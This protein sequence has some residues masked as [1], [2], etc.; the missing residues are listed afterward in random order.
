MN[1]NIRYA[2]GGPTALQKYIMHIESDQVSETPWPNTPHRD[3]G[4][5]IN[6]NTQ[7]G[8]IL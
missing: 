2:G 1:V 6:E 7:L 5:I 8:N 4:G 3:G